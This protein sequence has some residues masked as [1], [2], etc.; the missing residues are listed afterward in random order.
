MSQQFI[1]C[2]LTHEYDIKNYEPQSMTRIGID[3]FIHSSI[4]TFCNDSITIAWR[5][6]IRNNH[7][8]KTDEE[9]IFTLY[10]KHGF[11]ELLRIIDADFDILFLLDENIYNSESFFY[12]ATDI[13]NRFQS[14]PI[15]I[16]DNTIYFKDS[17]ENEEKEKEG[18]SQNQEIQKNQQKML[19]ACYRVA[20]RKYKVC[21]KWKFDNEIIHYYKL[22]LPVTSLPP[23]FTDT[24]IHELTNYYAKQAVK[25]CCRDFQFIYLYREDL[26]EFPVASSL[27]FYSLVNE[28]NKGVQYISA[29]EMKTPIFAIKSRGH[30]EI[31]PFRDRDLHQFLHSLPVTIPRNLSYGEI[32]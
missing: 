22:C 23:F 16:S 14:P 3:I 29:N 2:D 31:M 25:K 10:Q 21:S 13:M 6:I 9:Y 5:G 30:Q 19:Q 28:S 7:S 15:Y 17:E 27:L 18:K 1:L 24:M 4:N 12:V 20:S 11:Y 32:Y 8:D 26:E